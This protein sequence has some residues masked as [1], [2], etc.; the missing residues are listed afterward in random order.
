MTWLSFFESISSSTLTPWTRAKE[1]ESGRRKGESEVEVQNVAR[2]E[3]VGKVEKIKV[4]RWR[5]CDKRN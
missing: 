5:A 1:T 4:D 2:L 3:L